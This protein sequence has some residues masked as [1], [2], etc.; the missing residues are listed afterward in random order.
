[1]KKIW[2]LLAVL[3]LALTACAAP[4]QEEE[5]E[6]PT[7][8][9]QLSDAVALC[10]ENLSKG[11]AALQELDARLL[12]GK[13]TAGECCT[14]GIWQLQCGEQMV[15]LWQLTCIATEKN[16]GTLDTLHLAWE[17][18]DYY[19]SEGDAAWSTVQG[20]GENTVTFN[21]EDSHL[22]AGDTACGAVCLK[23]PATA[24]SA[25]WDHT[26]DARETTLTAEG[27][28]ITATTRDAQQVWTLQLEHKEETP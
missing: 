11:Q 9:Q 22:A 16:P 20:R 5:S 7:Y 26:A 12:G 14:L 28:A 8:E 6:P 3:L 10:R 25:Q 27:D 19:R 21:I 24:Y 23:D 2:L 18:G 1:M 13:Q 17:G 15:L 4:P